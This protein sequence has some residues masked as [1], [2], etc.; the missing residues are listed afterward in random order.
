MVLVSGYSWTVHRV[1]NS[2]YIF[3]NYENCEFLKFNKFFQSAK[4]SYIENFL[5]TK[6]ESPFSVGFKLDKK[7]NISGVYICHPPESKHR[8][9]SKSKDMLTNI[10]GASLEETIYISSSLRLPSIG[11]DLSSG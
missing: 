8:N 9:G 11:N 5:P 1:T 4:N 6:G 2:E 3:I 7:V 10:L